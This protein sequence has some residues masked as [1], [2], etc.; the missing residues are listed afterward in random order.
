MSQF[1]QAGL[2]TSRNTEDNLK[3]FE[4][5]VNF[6]ESDEA[7]TLSK[8]YSFPVY[9]PRQVIEDFLAR[10]ELF[11]LIL[12]IQG[13]ILEF[14]TF[15]GGGTFSFGHFSSISEPQNL[16]RK[17]VTFDTFEGFPSTSEE[18]TKG[19]PDLIKVGGLKSQP[20]DRMEAALDIWNSNR[21]IPHIPKVEIVAGDIM[22]TLDP[23]LER[24]PH[25]L[26]ALIYMDFDLFEPTAHV[27]KRLLPRMQKGSIVAFDELNHPAFPGETLAFLQE[28]VAG[29]VTVNRIPFSSRIS[30]IQIGM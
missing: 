4:R 22:E 28:M 16:T 20:L 24:C 6:F 18:D 21:F 1:K 30:Y 5:V 10:Y 8:L 11:K 26:P 25:T 17:I 12:P 13:D 29:E 27:L 14:G 3:Y 23:F 19:N 7:D 2:Q 15:N 9:V